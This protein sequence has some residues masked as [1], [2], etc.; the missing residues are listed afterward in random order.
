MAGVL[1]AARVILLAA[2]LAAVAVL[3]AWAKPRQQSE[4]EI[5]L[6][7]SAVGVALAAAASMAQGPAAVTLLSIIWAA[8]VAA[9]AALEMLLLN[10]VAPVVAQLVL[11]ETLEQVA[12]AFLDRVITA[13]TPLGLA[14]AVALLV[15]VVKM[16]GAE[17]QQA[18]TVQAQAAMAHHG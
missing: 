16:V 9:V 14:L 17:T 13:A 3:G 4:Q 10:L 5:L 12:L 11:M 8:Q 1:L 6:L 2:F 18:V 7:L 15:A